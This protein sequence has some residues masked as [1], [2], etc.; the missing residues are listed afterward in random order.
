MGPANYH[1]VWKWLQSYAKEYRWC[2]GVE[3]TEVYKGAQGAEM[4]AEG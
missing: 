1:V 3:G 2:I 4:D